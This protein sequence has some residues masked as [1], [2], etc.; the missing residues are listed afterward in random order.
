[1]ITKAVLVALAGPVAEMIH[2]G[3][4]FHPGIIP[5]WAAD[6]QEAWRVA[7]P[8][9]PDQR[10]RLA[11]LERA[12][13]QLYRLLYRDDHWAA[14]AAIVDH[15]VAHEWLEGEDVHEI[16]SHWMQ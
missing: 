12:T 13:T 1:M 8:L 2:R 14:L 16:V 9:Y 4:P 11:Y 5:E 15:L 10:Q 6:W 3:E 7:A